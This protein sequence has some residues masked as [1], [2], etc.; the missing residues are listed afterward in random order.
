MAFWKLNFFFFQES[1]VLTQ[2]SRDLILSAMRKYSMT[3]I[4]TNPGEM[5]SL[6]NKDVVAVEKLVHT[7]L[8]Q[9]AQASGF[10]LSHKKDREFLD[11]FVNIVSWITENENATKIQ[12]CFNHEL[13]IEMF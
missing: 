5:A 6:Y 12:V 2:K 10:Q 3:G 7:V 9:E 11:N 8:D 4:S 1:W 13:L